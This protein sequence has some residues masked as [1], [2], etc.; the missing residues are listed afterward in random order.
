MANDKWF[1]NVV[2]EGLMNEDFN[3]KHPNYAGGRIEI[4]HRDY[5][6]D[7]EEIRLLLPREMFNAV[8]D[9]VDL[10][11][12]DCFQIGDVRSEDLEVHANKLIKRYERQ[13]S[14]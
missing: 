14:N 1:F 6:Y 5:P 2:E 9:A 12:L 4:W 10:K 13:K 8:R 11:D 7:I 3:K